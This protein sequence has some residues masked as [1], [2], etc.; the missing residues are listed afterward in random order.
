MLSAL[1]EKARL[2]VATVKA[3]VDIYE[4]VRSQA[5][6]PPNNSGA[7]GGGAGGT[8]GLPVVPPYS[9]WKVY[10]HCAAYTK[11]YA[12]WEGFV[13]NLVGSWL[14]RLPSLYSGYSELPERVRKG[15]SHGVAVVLA[16][17][18]SP[19]H[20]HLSELNML[21][22]LHSGLSGK[23]DYTLL[24]EAFFHDGQ[25]LK[26]DTL[27]QLLSRLSLTKPWEWIG[28]QEAMIDY[29]GNVRGGSSTP[30][31]ELRDLVKRRN[32]ASHGEVGEVVSSQ[33]LK[34]VADYV[35]ILCE[36][37]ASFVTRALL[38]RMLVVGRAGEVGKVIHA[39]SDNL[40]EISLTRGVLRVG[41]RVFALRVHEC[42]DALAIGL[43][44]NGMNVAQVAGGEGVVVGVRMSR[45]VHLHSRLAL[46]P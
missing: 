28:R 25:N 18:A 27:E 31:S 16:R 19:R 41:E 14:A 4:S 38:D 42:I 24:P 17:A 23:A 40:V 13:R 39:Y 33:E 10:D 2:E 45:R 7:A 46:I 26:D 3:T 30:R 8:H 34:K 43:Q 32:E 12:I 1:V 22:G 21:E 35:T 29:M 15:H 20:R 9:S 6:P 5:Y 11:L 44:V 37:T 36:A